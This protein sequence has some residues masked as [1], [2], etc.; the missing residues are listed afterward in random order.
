MGSAQGITASGGKEGYAPPFFTENIHQTLMDSVSESGVLLSTPTRSHHSISATSP[1]H[2]NRKLGVAGIGVKFGKR[3]LV[4]IGD[5]VMVI[6]NAIRKRKET[7]HVVQTAIS[8]N[9]TSFFEIAH[10]TNNCGDTACTVARCSSAD[11]S[12]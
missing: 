7:P 11:E 8:P 3:Q 9:R 1:R 10:F 6:P 4:Q 12:G 2:V 5:Y